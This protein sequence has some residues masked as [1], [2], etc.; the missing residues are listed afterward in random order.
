MEGLR[1]SEDRFD[2]G[3]KREVPDLTNRLEVRWCR[4]ET[5]CETVNVRVTGNSEAE[6]CGVRIEKENW[7]KYLGATLYKDGRSTN[8]QYCHD[9]NGSDQTG[10]HHDSRDSTNLYQVV[11]L[12]WTWLAYTERRIQAFENYLKGLFGSLEREGKIHDQALS[13]VTTLE[14]QQEPLL[15]RINRCT[16]VCKFGQVTQHGHSLQDCLCTFEDGLRLGGLKKKWITNVK[17]RTDHP[18]QDLLT[19]TGVSGWPCQLSLLSTCFPQRPVQVKGWVH[20]WAMSK[21]QWVSHF[22]TIK[23]WTHLITDIF[24]SL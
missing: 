19:T 13:T 5:I 11:T 14:G 15:T 4:K 24:L 18:V 9:N 22:S 10:W 16:L 12:L 8:D 17:E 2:A 3:N 1:F 23:P 20:K 7:L 6:I 21:W